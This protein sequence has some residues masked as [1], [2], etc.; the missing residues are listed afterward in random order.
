MGLR[1]NLKKGVTPVESSTGGSSFKN[2]RKIPAV[3][4]TDPEKLSKEE[5]ELLLTLIKN[6]TF[7]GD[8]L[9]L[10]YT[11]TVKLQNK[12]KKL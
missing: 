3:K 2:T 8:I 12:Y 5:I 11:T 1:D 10:V 4:Y 9:D 6:T 7:K